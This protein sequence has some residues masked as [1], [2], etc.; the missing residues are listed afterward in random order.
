MGTILRDIL[1]MSPLSLLTR[2]ARVIPCA[3]QRHRPCRDPARMK[4]GN[5]GHL[6]QLLTFIRA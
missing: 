5:L 4:T 3:L 1:H 6:D 2:L